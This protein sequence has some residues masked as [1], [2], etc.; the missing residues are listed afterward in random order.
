LH[1]QLQQFGDVGF[2]LAVTNRNVPKML[3]QVLSVIA[4]SDI[5]VADMINKSRNDIAYNLIDIAAQPDAATLD[6]IRA[7]DGVINVR[8]IDF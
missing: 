5:N 8:L 6:K 1:R 2:R 7:I 4:E 3:G